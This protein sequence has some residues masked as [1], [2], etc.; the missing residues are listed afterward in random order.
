MSPFF[1][2]VGRKERVNGQG[3]GQGLGRTVEGWEEWLRFEKT[4][5]GVGRRVRGRGNEYLNVVVVFLDSILA[6]MRE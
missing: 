4:D 2:L 5:Q 6:M 3:Q 1:L